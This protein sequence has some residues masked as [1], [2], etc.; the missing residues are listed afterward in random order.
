MDK[1]CVNDTGSL[2]IKAVFELNLD[3][4]G[5]EGIGYIGVTTSLELTTSNVHIEL[6]CCANEI[7]NEV[8]T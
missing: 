2:S 8:A 5:I 6:S 1:R 7:V 3:A 4:L